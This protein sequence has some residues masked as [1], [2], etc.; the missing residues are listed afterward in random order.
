MTSSDGNSTIKSV[1]QIDVKRWMGKWGEMGSISI[2]VDIQSIKSRVSK[3]LQH[4]VLSGAQ[5]PSLKKKNKK[6]KEKQRDFPEREK[7]LQSA[8]TN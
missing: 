6:E 2:I 7:K 8:Q 3:I 1:A 4:G 5:N